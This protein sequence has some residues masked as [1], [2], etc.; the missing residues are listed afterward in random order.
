MWIGP[1]ILSSIL[2][3]ELVLILTQQTSHSPELK[4]VPPKAVGISLFSTYLLCVEMASMLLLAG[5]IGAYH[6]RKTTAAPP[7]QREDE[8]KG[9]R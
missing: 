1:G 9:T 8:T 6:L 7:S 4:M 3:I 2:L 5:F